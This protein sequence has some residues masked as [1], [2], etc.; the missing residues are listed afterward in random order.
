MISLI[1]IIQTIFVSGL[2]FGYYRLFLHNRPFHGFNRFFLLAIPVFSFLLP[3]LH[4]EMPSAWSHPVSGSPIH[5]L[6][7]GQGKWEEAVTVYGTRTHNS[8]PSGQLLLWIVLV[9]VSVILFIRLWQ[10]LRYL[11]RLRRSSPYTLLA[12]ATIYFVSEKGTPFS[13]FKS[14]FWGKDKDIDD[15]AG[16]QVLRHEL[17]H[18]THYHSLDSIFLEMLSIVFWFNPF[19]FFIRRELRAVHEYAADAYA[20]QATDSYC[21]ARLLLFNAAGTAVPFAHPF[22]SNQI[23]RRIMMITGSQ[24]NNKNWMGRLMIGP[25]MAGLIA[26][27][28]FKMPH[29]FEKHSGRTIR[30]VID[31]GHGGDY[32]GASWRGVMEKNINL[33]IA[34]KIQSLANQYQVS[35]LMTRQT[36]VSPGSPELRESLEYIAAMPKTNQA[37][38]FV[39]IHTNMVDNTGKGAFQTAKTG[40]EIYIPRNSSEVYENSLKLGSVLTEVIKSDY[41]IESTLKQIPPNGGNILILKK[42]SVPAVLIECGYMDNEKDLAYLTDEK[43]QEKIARDI[44]EGIR[45]YAAENLVFNSPSSGLRES[46]AAEDTITYQEMSKINAWDIDSITIIRKENYIRV[47]LKNGKKYLT[48]I[49]EAYLKSSDS[50]RRIHDSLDAV[51]NTNSLHADTVYK[52]VEVEASYPGGQKSW[53]DYLLKNLQYPQ[54]AVVKEIQGQVIVEFVVKADGTLSDIHALS[55]PEQLRGESVRIIQESGKWIPAK[56]NGKRV[57]SYHK[58]PL[59]YKLESK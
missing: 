32:S 55:G 43:N 45:K 42:A 19:L 25:L 1:Y 44:L 34:K 3:A 15:Q 16:K 9:A 26:L 20:A 39:S 59:N 21:Y 14:I 54:A 18:V 48:V 2:L 33:E 29:P 37:D 12:E 41:P 13:F 38:L 27:F 22:F 23:K 8:L 35:V 28:S 49:N 36:D 58:Q 57:D 40:F 6:E 30:V 53:Y 47:T 52:K 24:K 11:V 46:A 7:A 17:F 10:S 5:L 51:H 56:N 4:F 50:S 31:A